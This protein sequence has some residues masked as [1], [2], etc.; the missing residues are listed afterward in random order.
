MG[1]GIVALSSTPLVTPPV[2]LRYFLPPDFHRCHLLHPDPFRRRP[3]RLSHLSHTLPMYKS[4]LD[5]HRRHP[6]HANRWDPIPHG[7]PDQCDYE[8]LSTALQPDGRG[9]VL[10]PAPYP[11]HMDPPL[12]P[13][14]T[15]FLAL[16][17]PKR[18]Y[19]R[20]KDLGRC[21]FLLKKFV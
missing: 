4:P 19:L 11:H 10:P 14:R 17:F 5:D 20:G 2:T 16:H 21:K 13:Y 6:R 1:P 18:Y 12:T 8:S 15:L 9:A 3:A 7:F